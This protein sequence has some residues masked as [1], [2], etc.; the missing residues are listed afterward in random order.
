L[1]DDAEAKCVKG[2][3]RCL[4]SYYNQPDHELIDRTDREVLEI[5]IRIAR[6]RIAPV[7]A[8]Q[9]NTEDWS[10]RL[11]NWRVPSPDSKPLQ[12]GEQTFP[13]VWRSHLAVAATSPISERDKA[14]LEALGF[15][16]VSIDTSAEPP[17]DLLNLLGAHQ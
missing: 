11:S 15:S 5:L 2:C 13:L 8:K 3:Y 10:Q 4:L 12:L 1:A 17:A 14:D 9:A 16:V 7:K 6:G